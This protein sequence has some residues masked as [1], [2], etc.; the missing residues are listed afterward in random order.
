M[1]KELSGE[2]LGRVMAKHYSDLT[3]DEW[4]SLPFEQWKAKGD[5]RRAAEAACPKHEAQDLGTHDE[6]RRGWHRLR[7][8]HC[9]ADMSYDSGD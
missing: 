6:H 3:T 4:R 5:E 2:E 7:C 9:G 1:A 8:K